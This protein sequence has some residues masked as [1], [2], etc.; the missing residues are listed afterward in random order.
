MKKSSSRVLK[1]ELGHRFPEPYDSPVQE[2]HSRGGGGEEGKEVHFETVG[3]DFSWRSEIP[4]E[5]DFQC[6]GIAEALVLTSVIG[7]L[8]WNCFHSYTTTTSQKRYVSQDIFSVES[9]TTC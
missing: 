7:Q 3:R 5:G 6:I 4:S 2:A 9:A 8:C 1:V